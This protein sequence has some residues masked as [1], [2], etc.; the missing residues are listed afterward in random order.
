M[1][2]DPIYRVS[3]SA[4]LKLKTASS[5]TFRMV[6]AAAAALALS[7]QISRAD[8]NAVSLWLPGQFGSLAAAPQVPG[9]S[10]GVVAYHTSVDAS[11]NVAAER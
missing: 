9:W 6:A 8:E 5:N 10:L 11:G 1:N 4:G 3:M 7:P 2:S